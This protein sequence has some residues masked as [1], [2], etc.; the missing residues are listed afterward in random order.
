[1]DYEELILARQ[2]SD[3]DDCRYCENVE[4]CRLGIRVDCPFVTATEYAF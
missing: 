2:E 3:A 4:L 1:M